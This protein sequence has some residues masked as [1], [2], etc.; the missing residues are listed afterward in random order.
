MSKKKIILTIFIFVLLSAI[1]VLLYFRISFYDEFITLKGYHV[2][3]ACG[4]EGTTFVIEDCSNPKFSFLKDKILVIEDE[5]GKF[6]TY[7]RKAY[8][9]MKDGEVKLGSFR[10]TGYLNKSNFFGCGSDLGCFKLK[11]FDRIH[12]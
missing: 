9:N 7:L 6:D 10:L 1:S 3:S 2:E 12:K 8:G 5:K 4:D 11:E